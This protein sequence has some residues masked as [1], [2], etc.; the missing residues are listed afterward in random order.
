MT[1][2][3]LSIKGQT[4]IPIDIQRALNLQPGDK[5]Q[6]FIEADGRVSLLPRTLSLKNLG[7]VLP[8]PSRTVSL[9]EMDEAVRR[10]A[11]R[12]FRDAAGK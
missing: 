5:I 7:R 1:T 2:S 11:A 9:D 3:T 6:Y 10:N 12:N 8:K 4:T